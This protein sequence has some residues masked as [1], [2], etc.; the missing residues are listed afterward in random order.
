MKIGYFADGPWSHRALDRI[1]EDQQLEVVF[2]VVRN[3]HRDPVLQDYAK[4]MGVPC[5]FHQN[6][7]DDEFITQIKKHNA[8]LFVSMSFNQI[9]QENICKAAPLGFINCHAGA[10]PFYRG[11][12]I[13]N[14]ALI[15][16]EQDF[17]VTVIDVDGGIDTGSIITQKFAP[18]SISDDYASLLEKA[19]ELCA[20]ALYE[21]LH[22]IANGRAERKKQDD[23]HPVGTYFPRRRQGDEYID[24]NW[25]A[26]RV[27]D[28]IRAITTPGPGARTLSKKG[29][30]AIL[31]SELIKNAPSYLSR[32]GEVTGRCE[33]GTFVKCGDSVLLLTKVAEVQEDQT[34]G[35]A[36]VPQFPIGKR[37][38]TDPYQKMREL[39]ERL[40]A[41]ENK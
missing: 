23:I 31:K 27:F 17:G 2:I 41:L 34:L 35:E 22:L 4:R 29:E 11:R 37:L 13:L 19:Y 20:D 5:L 32:V 3:D 33:R 1:L 21:A 28:F 16:G 40:L 14:W 39:E 25:P 36:F 6:V 12:N 8:D 10:L 38:G 26:K 15:N 18:I 30:L 9:L 7:N 24:W